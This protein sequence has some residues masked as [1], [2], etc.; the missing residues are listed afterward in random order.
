MIL[1]LP[2]FGFCLIESSDCTIFM[3]ARGQMES[4]KVCT[5][6]STVECIHIFAAAKIPFFYF[7]QF[8]NR[9]LC[10][11]KYYYPREGKQD[12]PR[13]AQNSFILSGHRGSPKGTE[14]NVCMGQSTGQTEGQPGLVSKGKMISGPTQFY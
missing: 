14:Q 7:I 1:C 9:C 6:H 11:K 3:E 5:V 4:W 12:S 8:F 13:G 10:S 2:T